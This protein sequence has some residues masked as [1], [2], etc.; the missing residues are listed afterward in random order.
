MPLQLEV[1]ISQDESPS[2]GAIETDVEELAAEW[3]DKVVT[4]AAAL[5]TDQVRG[6]LVRGVLVRGDLPAVVWAGYFPGWSQRLQYCML[7]SWVRV[8]LAITA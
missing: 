8:L 5:F 4:A 7:T 6:V 1:L 3:L 2:P